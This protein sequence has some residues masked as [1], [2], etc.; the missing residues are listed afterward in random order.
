MDEAD[1]ADAMMA[2][3]SPG[4][5]LLLLVLCWLDFSS[6]SGLLPRIR[7]V[8]ESFPFS[9]RRGVPEKFEPVAILEVTSI[10][11]AA[12]STLA[13]VALLATV[14]PSVAF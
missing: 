12:I 5:V 8:I 14:E 6:L 4:S 10:F 3:S 9:C 7:F 1:E 2:S 11:S 13:A